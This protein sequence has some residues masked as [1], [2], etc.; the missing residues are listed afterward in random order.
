VPGFSPKTKGVRAC[1]WLL[2]PIWRSGYE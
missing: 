2:T 1:C